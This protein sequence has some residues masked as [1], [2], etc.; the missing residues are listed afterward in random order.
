M[1]APLSW[2]FLLKAPSECLPLHRQRTGEDLSSDD[3]LEGKAAI[4]LSGGKPIIK[5]IRRGHMA[6]GSKL[7]R[8]RICEE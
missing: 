4:G 6:G 7:I 3:R 8:V 2:T 1:L 5:L